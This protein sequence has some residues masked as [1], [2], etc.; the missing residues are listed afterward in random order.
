MTPGPISSHALPGAFHIHSGR[1]EVIPYNF[2]PT[3]TCQGRKPGYSII[4]RGWQRA[5][6]FSQTKKIIDPGFS[7]KE[8]EK[9]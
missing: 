3:K 4:F 5:F 1:E 6:P 7:L 8:D 2:A 9:A